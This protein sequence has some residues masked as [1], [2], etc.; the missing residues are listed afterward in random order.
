LNARRQPVVR[1]S[2]RQSLIALAA[3][4]ATTLAFFP[5]D[6]RAESLLIQNARLIDGTGAPPRGPVSILV[7]DGRISEIAQNIAAADVSTLDVAGSTVVPGLIDAHV[8]LMEVPGSDVR[9]DAPER[10][11]ALQHEQLRSYL[12]CGVTTVLDAATTVA[13]ARELH[14]WVASGHAGPT[15]LTLGPPIAPRGGYMSGT[16]PDL[17]VGSIHDLDRVFDAIA[18]VGA[19]G[20]KVPLERGFGSDAVF[21]IH[22]PEVRD[23]IRRKAAE[24]HLPIYVHA[25]DE[26]EQTIGL[27]MG[28][29]AL[30]HLNF[31]NFAGLEASPEFI[32]RAARAGTYMVTT[33][34]IIDA[35]L[36][37]WETSRLDDASVQLAVP[38]VERETARSAGAWAARDVSE[39]GFA[40]PRWPRLALRVFARL[41]PPLE[42]PEA[43][44][45]AAN[46]RSAK[47][48][49][50]AGVPLVIG[51]DAGN[52]SLLSAFHGT[53]TVR[54]LELLAD[55]GV[56][57]ADVL[58][59]ATRVSAEMLGI[60]GDAGTVERG[61]RGDLVVLASD[62]LANIRAIRT[63]RW[64]VKAGVV[65]TPQEWMQQP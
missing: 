22:S 9:G 62:P 60:S 32:A 45:L 33:F 56:P 34:S 50:D 41:S 21:P 17:T 19:I 57:A 53:S 3:I 61:K 63:I 64:T 16:N 12:A 37:R 26:V 29:H 13:G 49:Y 20:V 44:A 38:V 55:A 5:L 23:A 1:R 4:A 46:L 11:L 18:S 47:Q 42:A 24:R 35:G 51:S 15:Y 6:L 65:H 58:A 10:L 52:S 8:H 27:D 39:L 28:A 43:A 14:A 36:A 30:A 7:R 40:F 59:A 48:L 25:S 31:A 54:E 2:G